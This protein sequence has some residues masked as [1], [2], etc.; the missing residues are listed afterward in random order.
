VYDIV[1]KVQANKRDKSEKR[2]EE[3]KSINLIEKA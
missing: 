2:E 1:I 3:N